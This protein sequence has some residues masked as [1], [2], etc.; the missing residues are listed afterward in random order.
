MSGSNST[1]LAFVVGI[2]CLF[3]PP[4]SSLAAESSRQTIT[5]SYMKTQQMRFDVPLG[6]AIYQASTSIIR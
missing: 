2:V 6:K 4:D 5:C 3:H 1:K